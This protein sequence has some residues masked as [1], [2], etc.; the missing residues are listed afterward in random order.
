MQK[1]IKA[2]IILIGVLIAIIFLGWLGLQVKL[3]PFPA[4]SSQ[5]AELKTIPLPKDLPAPVERFYR[6][7]YGENIPVITSAVISG[8]ARLRPTGPVYLPSRFRFIHIAG[9]SYRHYIE[10]GL[11]GLPLLKINERYLEGKSRMELPFFP[12]E[13]NEPKNNQGANLGLW[14]ESIWLPS[15]F[16]T[17]P[18][19]SWEAVDDQTALLSVPFEETQER[20]V[21]RF[22]PQNGMIRYIESMRY[23]GA[24]SPE[25]T[26]WINETRDWGP[27]DGNQLANVGAVTW[28]DSGTPWAIFTIEDVVY[29]V[30]VN[31]YIRA[32]GE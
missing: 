5:T 29:N 12:A 25:K 19:V 4:Y 32:K 16:I 30:D 23:H 2:M 9:Q 18:R 15:I 20:F 28:M 6:Q 22:D 1:V 7:I 24:A 21:I 10:S 11:Y 8:R 27:V 17:D 26:L 13:E 3:S 31:A 14:A